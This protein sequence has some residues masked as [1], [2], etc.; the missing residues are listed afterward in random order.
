MGILLYT[1]NF[2]EFSIKELKD[3]LELDHP[4]MLF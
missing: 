3:I 4:S 1:F 2:F